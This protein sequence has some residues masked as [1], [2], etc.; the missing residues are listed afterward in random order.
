MRKHD[1]RVEGKDVCEP[2]QT[3]EAAGFPHD[4]MDEVGFSA[5]AVDQH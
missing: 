3:F 5:V 1:L 2:F 4:I